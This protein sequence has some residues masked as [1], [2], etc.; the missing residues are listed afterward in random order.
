M[1]RGID[2]IAKPILVTDS[3]TGEDVR[4]VGDAGN[5]SIR[6]TLVSGGGGAATV[7][8]GA[9]VVEG[10][11]ADAAVA[12]GAAG[13]FSAKFRRLTT[14]LGALL[15]LLP[16]SLGTKA[17]AASLAV[18]LA[19]DD[20][21]NAVL[22]A[23]SGAA[24]VT[25]ANGTVQQYL[26]GLIKNLAAGTWTMLLGAGEAHIGAVGGAT[27]NPSANF[28][29][30][31]DTT[32]YASGDLVAN[33]VTAGSV[34]PLSWTVARVAAGSG[35]VRRA[36]VKKSGTTVTNAQFRLHLYAASP[37]VTNGDNGVWLSTQSS[38]LGSFDVTVDKVFSDAAEGNGAPLIGSEVNFA[39]ASGQTIYG[40]LEARAAYTPANAEVFTVELEVLQ[41]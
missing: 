36:R 31:T 16:A 30:P 28:T 20:P 9:N 6:V 40:L 26:R 32:P 14:D 17:A 8:D 39:L 15:G 38:Y 13:T 37:T 3:A 5:K 24:V 12:A 11:L 41:N 10:A 19:S 7:A 22:G 34:T 21:G 2:T 35:M 25:D 27:T 23:T 4:D 29:R 18:T 33:N 1:T